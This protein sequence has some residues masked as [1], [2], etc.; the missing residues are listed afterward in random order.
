ME[1][2]EIEAFLAIAEYGTFTRAAAHL[3]ISQPAISR[4]IELLEMDLE[5][6]LFRRDR[7]GA[8]LTPAGTAFLPFARGAMA[9]IRDSVSAVRE[10]I[11]GSKGDLLLA[12]VG[13]L[14]ST[15][16]LHSLRRFRE[17]HADIRLRVH[18]A[19]S[20]E[21]SELVH[22][23]KA[24]LGLRYFTSALPGLEHTTVGHEP[25]VIVRAKGSA[26]VP[27][28]IHSADQLASVP[29]VSFPIGAG[30]SGE[31]FAR[32][33]ERALIR[34]GVDDTERI[35]IDS[36]TAQKRMIEADF[37]VGLLPKSSITEEARLRTLEAVDLP[38][39]S[40][41]VPITL[42]HRRDGF[43]SGAMSALMRELGGT[44]PEPPKRG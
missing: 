18:T 26:L 3:G 8:H 43:R 9:N 34:L 35:L 24:E 11:H 15:T 12:I 17:A 21:V 40:A 1:L 42:V 16:L 32:E 20:H 27:G 41:R 39:F 13:T 30:S 14:A 36:L 7:T 28:P 23:G 5:T 33:T 31:P 38:G 2:I 10:V 44:T 4:R 22:S 25:L 19:N 6:P 29:W 37:G